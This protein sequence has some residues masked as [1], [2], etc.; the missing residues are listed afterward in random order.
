MENQKGFKGIGPNTGK[1]VS[2]EDAFTHAAREVGILVFN[3]TAA[4]A[5]EFREML[6]EWYF[7][8]NWVEV[9]SDG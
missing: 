9:D 4:D 6:V 8:G 2:A 5:E 1:F 3:H 7:S